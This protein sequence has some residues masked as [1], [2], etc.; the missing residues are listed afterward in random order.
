MQVKRIKAAVEPPPDTI[1]VTMTL[2]EAETLYYVSQ[3]NIRIPDMAEDDYGRVAHVDVYTV[4]NL[5]RSAL[6]EVGVRSATLTR[7]TWTR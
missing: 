2:D 3:M 1:Q 5:L 4:L 6:S 7:G